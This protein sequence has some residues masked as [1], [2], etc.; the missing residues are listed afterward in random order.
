[1]SE[2]FLQHPLEFFVD[3]EYDNYIFEKNVSFSSI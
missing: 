2:L 1:M 3:V